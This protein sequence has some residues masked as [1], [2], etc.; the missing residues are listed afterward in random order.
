MCRSDP[1]ARGR[2]AGSACDDRRGVKPEGGSAL[3]LTC[4]RSAAAPIESVSARAGRAARAAALTTCRSRTLTRRSTDRRAEALRRQASARTTAP[5]ARPPARA[6][7]APAAAGPAAERDTGGSNC[8][9]RCGD[10]SQPVGLAGRG[11]SGTGGGGGAF[12]PAV[13]ER[14]LSFRARADFCCWRLRRRDE[15]ESFS[16]LALVR[17]RARPRR[18][19][20]PPAASAREVRRRA[21][22]AALKQR[23]SSQPVG[24]GALRSC[25]GR[26]GSG[27]R[28]RL[29]LRDGPRPESPS[30]AIWFDDFLDGGVRCRVD[31]ELVG[32]SGAGSSTDGNRVRARGTP[33]LARGGARQ[34]V[35]LRHRLVEGRQVVDLLGVARRRERASPSP[36]CRA[37]ARSRPSRLRLTLGRS[38]LAAGAKACRSLALLV[39]AEWSKLSRNSSSSGT[40]GLF[41]GALRRVGSSPRAAAESSS[42]RRAECRVHLRRRSR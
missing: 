9:A 31:R 37:R 6:A 23:A 8:A 33:A 14:S 20:R 2:A 3:S 30:A 36:D 34:H 41:D 29:G 12:C 11:G 39:S 24:D 19:V 40:R 18:H 15:A 28:F 25:A 17:A 38:P 26:S 27:V 32:D 5:R 35:G 21:A 13:V 7:S 4:A 10:T 16:G 42:A 1:V 22:A